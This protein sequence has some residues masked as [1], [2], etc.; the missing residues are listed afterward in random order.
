MVALKI[1]LEI[2]LE[3]SSLRRGRQRVARM[4]SDLVGG[5]GAMMRPPTERDAV[6]EREHHVACRA[7]SKRMVYCPLTLASNST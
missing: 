1:V 4:S 7:R 6:G 5:S 2:V 3:S